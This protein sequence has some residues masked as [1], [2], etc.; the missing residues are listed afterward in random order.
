MQT[1]IWLSLLSVLLLLVISSLFSSAETG[2]TAASKARIHRLAQDG[3]RRAAIVESMFEVRDRVVG[4]ILLANNLVNILASALTTSLLISLFGS[5]GVIYATVIK[6]FALGR[7]ERVALAL[8]PVLNFVTWLLAPVLSLIDRIVRPIMRAIGKS[9][10][11]LLSSQDEIRGAID[12]HAHEGGLIQEHKQMLGSILDLD[13]VVIGDVM[14]NRQQIEMIDADEPVEKII[15]SIVRSSHTR[16]PLY[17]DNQENIIGILHAKDVL[18]AINRL[19]VKPI[20]SIKIERIMS[21]PVFAPDT[22]TLR[23]QLNAF[24]ALRNHFALVVDEYGALQGLLTLEDILEE[25]VGDITDE[26]DLPIPEGVHQLADGALSIEGG[27][28]LRDLN[29]RFN[30]SLPDDEATTIAGLVINEA[31]VI[32]QVGEA[33]SFFGFEFRIL[34]RKRNR[35]TLIRVKPPLPVV[36]EPG[37]VKS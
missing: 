6:T 19:G 29:R 11:A 23:E 10:D 13:D 31:R 15:R 35:I 9:G 2:F 3:N 12:L 24:I 14:V 22:T 5:T 20:S 36:L 26:H 28:T 1:T 34:E 18:R 21:P 7:P 16:I 4:A 30:W 25:I 8:A 27:V 17:R 33:F 32:P 37:A